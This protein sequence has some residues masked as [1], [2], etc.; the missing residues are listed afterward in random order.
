ML[1][2]VHRD[3]PE[4]R[5]QTVSPPRS[6]NLEGIDGKSREPKVSGVGN[7]D[8]R[9]LRRSTRSVINISLELLLKT[10]SDSFPNSVAMR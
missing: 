9:H 6:V 4:R 3:K 7:G 2:G 1:R 5:R 10:F 8:R